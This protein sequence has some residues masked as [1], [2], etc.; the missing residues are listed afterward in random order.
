MEMDLR[1][2]LSSYKRDFFGGEEIYQEI[3]ARLKKFYYLLPKP[4][5]IFFRSPYSNEYLKL[6]NFSFTAWIITPYCSLFL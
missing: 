3:N 5:N 1:F 2:V 6:I 4:K